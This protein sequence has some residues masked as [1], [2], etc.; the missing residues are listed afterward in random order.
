MNFPFEQFSKRVRII[1]PEVY[2]RYG[3]IMIFTLPETLS[4]FR[5]FFVAYEAYRGETHPMIGTQ[6]IAQIIERMAYAEMDGQEPVDI[7]SEDYPVLV[8]AYFRTRFGE[9]CDYRINH[10]FSGKIRALKWLENLY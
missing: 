4:V 10:F 5:C 1:Y 7:A 2:Q 6:Q 9:G 8:D 3:G